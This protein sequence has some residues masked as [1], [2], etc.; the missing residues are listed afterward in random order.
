[1]TT[2][3][4][5]L[6]VEDKPTELSCT[7]TCMSLAANLLEFHL[8]ALQLR[9][10]L[11]IDKGRFTNVHTEI[12]IISVQEQISGS[13]QGSKPSLHYYI[14]FPKLYILLTVSAAISAKKL[15][16]SIKFRH[17]EGGRTVTQASPTLI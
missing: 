17:R 9:D 3:R 6:V 10:M 4:L 14:A 12:N 1:M 11:F 7:C 8:S 15:D 2:P 16:F 5:G 13:K